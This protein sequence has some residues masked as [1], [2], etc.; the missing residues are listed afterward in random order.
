MKVSELIEKLQALDP[1]LRVVVDGYEGGV[2]EASYVEVEEIALNVNEERY[3][4]PHE[5]IN[6]GCYE[7]YEGHE[8]IQAVS[9]C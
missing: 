5:I 4:G 1:D 9:I 2:K 6:T 7:Q 3:Y 8:R